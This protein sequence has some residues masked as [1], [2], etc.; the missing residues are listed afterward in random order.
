MALT[1]ATAV[2]IFATATAAST[3]LQY[4]QQ[5]K[6][7]KAQKKR[8]AVESAMQGEEVARRRRQTIREAAMRRAEIENI[9]AATGQLESSAPI[10]AGQQVTAEEQTQLGEIS[11]GLGIAKARTAAEQEVISAQQVSPLQTLAGTGQ[12]AAIAFK[13]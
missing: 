8:A 2:G 1:T 3:V 10:V 7:E 6:V 12:Q 9:A 4:K 13:Q 5:K 11:T